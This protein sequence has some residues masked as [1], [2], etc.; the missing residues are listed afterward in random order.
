MESILILNALMVNEGV[1]KP[2]DIF[3]KN[4]RIETIG[5]SL[6]GK[7]ADTVI[8]AGGSLL[9]PGMID[10]HVHCRE[11]GLTHKGD[12]H[13]ETRA[14]VAGGITSIMEMPN[15]RPPTVTHALLEEKFAIAAAIREI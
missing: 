11:P 13:T 2:A 7:R 10:C 1:R 14:A 8:D 12:L 9:L 6:S 4:G 3:I 5:G 15:T